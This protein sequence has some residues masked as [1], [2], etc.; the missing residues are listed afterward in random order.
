PFRAAT[1]LETLEQV[2]SAEPVAPARLRLNL[3]RDLETVCLKCL[4]KEPGRRY[5]SAA[6]LAEDLRRVGA[7]GPVRGRAV[8]GRGARAGWWGVRAGA[9]RDSPGG[10]AGGWLPRCGDPVVAGRRAPGRRARRP[11][12]GAGPVPARDGGRRRLLH[13]GRR[14]RAEGPAA[15]GPAQ[16]D[17]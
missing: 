17:A 8:G 7:G 10:G 15:G 11:P 5:D 14:G 13:P 6:E 2:K 12:A 16:E 9:G 4:R 3:P 1:A